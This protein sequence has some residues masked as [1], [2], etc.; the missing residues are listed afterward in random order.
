MSPGKAIA[1]R[2]VHQVQLAAGSALT[3]AQRPALAPPLVQLV[4]AAV[5]PFD[6]AVAVYNAQL[7][8]LQARERALDVL[9]GRL[10]DRQHS[11][12]MELPGLASANELEREAAAAKAFVNTWD[13]PAPLPA[14]NC[15]RIIRSGR[16][17]RAELCKSSYTTKVGHG[18]VVLS[19]EHD[20]NPGEAHLLA[21]GDSVGFEAP[22]FGLEASPDARVT[23]ASSSNPETQTTSYII[24]DVQVIGTH[25]ILTIDRK[26]NVAS[27]NKDDDWSSVYYDMTLSADGRRLVGQCRTAQ[28]LWDCQLSRHQY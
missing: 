2:L 8:T 21:N 25:L 1:K 18:P 5:L 12:E 24:S 13:T 20:D 14:G 7:Q 23:K 3:A 17:Y 16:T 19:K 9:A 27:V 22:K 15:I 26:S 6:Q 11:I 10:L 4:N 28:K